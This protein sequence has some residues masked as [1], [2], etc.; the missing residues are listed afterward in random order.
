MD[1]LATLQDNSHYLSRSEL[2][3]AEI[4]L[5]QPDFA[6]NAS[7]T[8]LATRAKVSPP[9]VTRF[10]R[11]LGC[12]SYSDFKVRLAQ[13]VF[14]GTRYLKPET[15]VI[16]ARDIAEN[17]VTKA[18]SALYSVHSSLD[19]DLVDRTAELIAKSKMVYA[20]GSGGNSAMIAHEVHNRL[21]RLGL[22]VAA[23]TDHTMQLM[24]AASLQTDDTVIV[25]SFSGRNAEL[26]RALE[27]ARVYKAK[28]VALTRPDTLVAKAADIV[29]PVDLPEG[30]NILRPTS[31]RY[32]F[33]VMLDILAN[34]VAV[35][36]KR[37]A[38]EP[39]RR[40]KH[41]LVTHRDEDDSEVM[42]D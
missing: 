31:S 2:R 29:L 1:I 42:G 15:K 17:I 8:E 11:R 13:T 33:L 22:R 9:T 14:V 19:V 6:T 32:G 4:V 41:Q 3:I 7:I 30:V 26:V 40:I 10:C 12:Q 27:T 18:Q 37:R 24:L 38:V 23:S 5:S 20:F 28:T 36:R 16:S 34:L 39:L 21:F 35:H 25:S